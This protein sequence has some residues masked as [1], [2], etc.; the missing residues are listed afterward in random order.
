MTKTSCIQHPASQS[1]VIVREDYRRLCKAAPDSNCAAAL[2]NL[3]EHWTN[4]KFA[5]NQQAKKQNA[6]MEQGGL[7]P[8]QDTDCW[9]WKTTE[10][11]QQ[12]LMHVWGKTKI[13]NA[14]AWLV[15]VKLVQCRTNPDYEWDRTYQYRLDTHLVTKYIDDPKG[16]IEYMQELNSTDGAVKSNQ[17]IPEETTEKKLPNGNC[18]GAHTPSDS[19]S[20]V[21]EDN[22]VSQPLTTTPM[23]P[24]AVHTCHECGS[25]RAYKHGNLY[26]CVDCETV[27]V[28]VK[29]PGTKPITPSTP[30]SAAPPSPPQR[31]NRRGVPWTDGVDDPPNAGDY[32]KARGILAGLV[33]DEPAEVSIRR[34][35]DGDNPPTPP[36][37][38]APSEADSPPGMDHTAVKNGLCAALGLDPANVTNWG[39]YNRVSKDMRKMKNPPQPD[40]FPE[41]REWDLKTNPNWVSTNPGQVGQKWAAFKAWQT[42]KRRPK[43]Y[44]E[45]VGGLQEWPDEP[46]PDKATQEKMAY[47]DKRIKDMLAAMKTYPRINEHGDLILDE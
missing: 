14:R 30:G 20:G 41:F 34:L 38:P 15:K 4:V 19:D 43:N 40:D 26:T 35:R 37:E 28:V 25:T 44:I 9:I 16:W 32:R 24:N 46:L 45:P 5:A 47:A 36:P 3:F 23:H 17:A 18:A 33:P 29:E 22:P 27:A 6:I 21:S 1:L 31:L 8:T 7:D 10:D 39:I 13:K 12:D 2:L 11:L 42:E